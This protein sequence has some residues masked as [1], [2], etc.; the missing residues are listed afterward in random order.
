MAVLVT[1][2]LW[3]GIEVHSA[4]AELAS[5]PTPPTPTVTI[6]APGQVLIGTQVKF[7]VTFKN[8]TAVGYGPF[9]DLVLDAGG[10]NAPKPCPCDGITFVQAKVVGVNGGPVMLTPSSTTPTLTTPCGSAPT[11]VPH[12][13]ASNGVLPVTLPAG[14]QMI[15]LALPFGSFDP[16]QPPIEVEVT[17]NVSN[18]ADYNYP[19][20]I[21][22]RGGFRYGTDPQDNPNP[23]YP[24]LTDESSP[25]VQITNSTMW[26]AQAQMTPKVMIINKAYLGP[27]GENATGPN[28]IG[29]YP[30]RYKLT[31]EVAPG[32][33]VSSVVLTDCLPANMAFHQLVSVTPGGA[34]TLPLIDVPGASPNCLTVNWPSLTGSAAVVFEFFIPEKDANGNPV[35]PADCTPA[36]SKDTINVTADWTPLDPCDKP[37]TLS[38]GPV[39]D[40][41]LDKCI[42]IQKSVA[43]ATDT[44]AAGYT[45][46]DT[47]KY[48]LNFQISDFKT[49]GALD[50]ID[51]LSDGQQLVS[52]A[53]TLTVSD[54]FGTTSGSF[55]LNSDLLSAP[56][57]SINCGGVIGGTKLT[58]LVSQKMI[59]LSPLNPRHAAGILTGG[60]ATSTPSSTPATG[61]IVFFA[62]ITDQFAFPHP[63]DSF[64]DK[65]DPINN[66]VLIGGKVMTNVN[67]PTLPTSTGVIGQ[68]DSS[69]AVAIVGDTLT[70]SVY[71]VKRSNAFGVF[72]IVCGPGGPRA[73]SNFPNP[74]EEVLPGDQVTFSL[75]KTIPSSDAEQLTIEDWLPL[76]VFNVASMS[77][78]NLP[79][80]IPA[81][82]RWCFGPGDQLHTLVAPKPTF[83]ANPATNSIKFDYSPNFNDPNNQPRMVELLFTSTVT[84]LPFAD[85]LFLTNEAQECEKNTFGATFCQVA[86]AQVNVRQPKLRIRK[87]VVAT[88]NPNAVF[89]PAPPAPT[90]VVFNLGGFVS[91]PINSSNVGLINSNVADVDAND[92]VTF[93]ITIE[94]LGGSPAYDVKIR[95]I[96]PTDSQG[97]PSCFTIVP[98]SI[99]LK[100]GT[101]VNVVPGL[102]TTQLTSNGFT[103]TS[104]S[105]PVPIPALNAGN[106]NNGAN[107]VV[108]SFQAKL[109]ANIKPG[110]CDNKVQLEHYSSTPGGPDFVS[111]GFTPPFDDVAQVCVKPTLTKSVVTT[112]EAHTVPQSSAMPQN[113][114]N[115]PQVTIGEIVR[116]RLLIAL[117]EGGVLTNFQVTDALPPGMKFM[118]AGTARI[119]FIANQGGII[120]SGPLSSPLFSAIGNAPLSSAA[121]TLKPPIPNGVITGGANCGSP[122]TFNLG[123]VQNTDNDN[124]LEYIEIEFNALVC[125]VAS[126]QNGVTLSNTFSVSA[127]GANLA[128]S[129]P[130]NVIV[131]EPNLTITKT[132]SPASVIHNGTASYT[133][134]ITNQGPV[135]AFDVQFTDTLPT[136]LTFVPASMT[137]TGSCL[138]T[139]GTSA[140]SPSVTCSNMPA[141]GTVTIKYNAVANTPGCPATITNK[142]AVTWTSLPGNGTPIG[143]NNLTGSTTPGLS[144]AGD[145]ERNGTTAPLTLN[146]Y[147]ATASAPLDVTCPPCAG[148]ATPPRGMV[149]WWR[150]D[151]TSGSVVHSIVGNHD[152]TTQPGAIGAGAISVA[153]QPKVSGALFFGAARA[154]VADDPALDFG[155]GDFSIDAWVRSYQSNLL[156]A[157]VDKLDT[158]GPARGYA[159]FVQNGTVQLVMANGTNTSTFQSSNTFVADGTW[160][161]VAV[162]VRRL[163]GTPVGQFYIDGSPAGPT[164]TPLAGNIDSNATL[165]IANYRLSA[166]QCSCEVSLDEIELFNTAV[167]AS[168]IKAIFAAGGNGK[169][170]A[171]INGLK[172]DDLNGNGVRDTGEPGLANWTIKATDS[173]GN[174]Q[175]TTTDSLGNYSFT[176]PAPGSYTVAEVLQTGWTQTAPATGTYTVVVSASQVINNRDF[177]NKKQ[178]NQCD[179]KITKEV[180]PNPLVNGQQAAVTI[181]VKNVGT[182]PCHGPTQ[183]TES[184]PGGL[185]LGSAS[186]PGGSCVVATGVCTYPPAILVNQT[187]VFTYI[188]KVNSQPGA[189]IENCATLK[190]SE[191]QNQTNDKDC[192]KLTV[193]GGK[194]PELTTI[195]KVR[196]GSLAGLLLNT[197]T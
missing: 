124:D 175:I 74:P 133:V 128:T 162:T 70:K 13:F 46:G 7:K 178:Q 31:V 110:C 102:Y 38:E 160:R 152:G 172:F 75:K 136:G 187:V 123:N 43:L 17:V 55:V 138:P 166:N 87:A 167:S 122:V 32:Q 114:A 158:S 193:G 89:T 19:L 21:S 79:C 27:E 183:V 90:P 92:T 146:D 103:I 159:F 84:N 151:E 42:A 77:F 177:G 129:N 58:F 184:M 105:L 101:G 134:T 40:T 67:P 180:K 20:K 170:K 93:A 189:I 68:D 113:P 41:L 163:G 28:F 137:V 49:F 117:P 153:T 104:S 34:T 99:Q 127:G 191:D 66:C 173:N 196:C 10:A 26:N 194:L 106:P 53:P 161:H 165:L 96:I 48:I 2:P 82:N 1:I 65:E 157:V 18:L 190:N 181:T 52:P 81:A 186:V 73:C 50:I 174:A 132:V 36:N 59:N 118:G 94:N 76:P 35:L 97:N 140:T 144:G 95:D 3:L 16:T 182:A 51:S 98:N 188:F 108:I 47:V 156:S 23:D 12:P 100:R 22:A 88:S 85:G 24:V 8:G 126:N 111:A 149:A 60:H 44:G 119:A 168:D 179:L 121:L 197:C 171:T 185:T 30:L 71:A 142:A 143:A 62:K 4:S 9:L 86:I 176:V 130:I 109:L 116:Y 91:G 15:T 54:Q 11:T 131:V 39:V 29:F 155:T 57:G 120:R 25:G 192:V 63:G 139:P 14:S 164:F 5:P 83:T 64:V 195:K 125:N 141:N 72:N 56:D 148:C 154:E 107:I 112:S 61:Q 33:T 37:Q 80:T 169:C 69:T 45:P 115:T 6:A 147:A 150:L 145:G 78:T 135:Q